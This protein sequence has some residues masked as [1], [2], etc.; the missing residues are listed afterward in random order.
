MALVCLRQ[1]TREA[2]LVL[3]LALIAEMVLGAIIGLNVI[4]MV[5]ILA[6]IWVSVGLAAIILRISG[7]LGNSLL[8][9]FVIGVIAVLVIYGISENP[10]DMWRQKLQGLP[11]LPL[12]Q[13]NLA[14]SDTEVNSVLDKI[15][16]LMTGILVAGFFTNTVLSLLLGRWM[17]ALLYNQG[18]F[19]REFHALR[20][21]SVA[22][23]ILLLLLL[24]MLITQSLLLAS[25]LLVGLVLFMFQGLATVHGLV[26]IKQYNKGWLAAIYVAIFVLPQMAMLLAVFGLID[27]W[28]DLRKRAVSVA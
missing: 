14:L 7:S 21:G 6:I 19:Q 24:L 23:V 4:M 13:K 8:F 27:T 12:L 22:A 17:Q 10:A 11:D 15:S 3:G 25:V 5:T 26:Q 28:V 20:L 9:L 1:S 18:G 2:A 16:K